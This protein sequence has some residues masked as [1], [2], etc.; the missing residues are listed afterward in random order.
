MW[1]L[2]RATRTLHYRSQTPVPG[3]AAE[4]NRLTS[5]PCSGW[6]RC[7]L[8][9]SDGV[10]AGTALPRW[11]LACGSDFRLVLNSPA[12]MASYLTAF[13]YL[14]SFPS[15]FPVPLLFHSLSIYSGH[16]LNARPWGPVRQTPLYTVPAPSRAETI[17]YWHLQD[18]RKCLLSECM[19]VMPF[20]ISVP[21][22]YL[23]LSS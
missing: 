11:P 21:L 22:V 12:S 9:K 10:T 4:S 3:K 7:A 14:P 16:F 20:L 1:L 15:F 5:E 23:T 13:S 2:F 17:P 8:T 18:L 6:M 19:N